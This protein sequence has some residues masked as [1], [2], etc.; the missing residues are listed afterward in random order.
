MDSNSFVNR[1][2][3]SIKDYTDNLASAIEEQNASMQE[4]GMSAKKISTES[5]HISDS[6]SSITDS[7]IQM[8]DDMDKASGIVNM[9]KL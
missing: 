1:E 7:V 9:Y 8:V 6:T 2:A 4:L 3:G 5:K